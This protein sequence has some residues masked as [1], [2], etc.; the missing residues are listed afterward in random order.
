MVRGPDVKME[1]DCKQVSRLISD[2]QDRELPAAEKARMR[3]H[4]VICSKC[5]VTSG[6]RAQIR[7]P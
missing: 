3:M 1:L 2:G 4:F 6:F 7:E 5:S